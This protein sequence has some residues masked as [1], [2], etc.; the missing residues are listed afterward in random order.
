MRSLAAPPKARR[1]LR[2]A[3]SYLLEDELAENL[4]HVHVAPMRHADGAGIALA[5]KKDLLENWLDTLE[6]AGISPDI[7]T[8]DFALLPMAAGR[9]IF[10]EQADRIVGAAEFS[11]FAMDRPLADDIAAAFAENENISDIVVYGERLLGASG[12]Q[13]VNIERRTAL[14]GEAL[15]QTFAAGVACAPNLRVGSYRKRRDWRAAAGPWRRVGMLA[16]ASLA[17]LVLTT[18]AESLRDYRTANKL[19]EATLALH[20]A[21]FPDAADADPRAHARQILAAGGGRPVFL[22]LTNSIAESAREN[23]GVEIDRIRYNGGRGEY[24]VNLRFG[25]ISKF[26]AFKRALASRGLDVTEAGSVLRAGATYRGELR[27]S[28]S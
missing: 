17:A 12:R 5:V 19:K 1:Q 25:D 4:D 26:E 7:V 20:Q 8:A 22:F 14:D 16:A 18:A 27:V 2:A 28:I 24:S 9:A 6:E 3:V 21:A 11:G 10:I 13:G 23:E 15:F